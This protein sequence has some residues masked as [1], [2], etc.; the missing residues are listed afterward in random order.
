MFLLLILCGLFVMNKDNDQ[1]EKRIVYFVESVE[2]LKA[3]KGSLTVKTI[4]S[5]P[6][7]CYQ[8][9]HIET[10]QIADTIHISIF[11]K[12]DKSVNCIQVL[13]KMSAEFEI[14]AE[15]GKYIL[16]FKGKSKEIF[17]EVT[18]K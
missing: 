3:E 6:N 5:V 18:V 10:E 17:K 11:A 1:F 7:P 14:V 4:S 15:P 12:I 13:G 16:Y 2:I 9:D 8:F